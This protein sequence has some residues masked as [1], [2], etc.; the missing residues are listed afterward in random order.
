M[1]TNTSPT[2]CHNCGRQIEVGQG[3]VKEIW[4]YPWDGSD[5]EGSIMQCIARYTICMYATE[6]A[7]HAADYSTDP[8][9]LRQIASDVENLD[10]DIRNRAAAALD[11]LREIARQTAIREE[12][13]M[14]E[15]GYGAI[16]S[17]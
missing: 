9:V 2:T 13:L 4:D 16:G 7:S 8:V 5:T 15:S 3:I 6:C 10:A 12:E 17:Y 1:N 14:R 11:D